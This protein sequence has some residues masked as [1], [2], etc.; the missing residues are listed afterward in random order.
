MD[1]NQRLE[2]LGDAIL[3]M[4][5]STKLFDLYQGRQ[6]ELHRLRSNIVS[7][8]NLDIVAKEKLALHKYIKIKQGVEPK[9]ADFL[10]VNII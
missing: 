4:I 3:G 5:I 10:E 9:M 1:N 7:N 6:G 8:R 2:F